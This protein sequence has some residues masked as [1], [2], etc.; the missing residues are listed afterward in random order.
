MFREYRF[1]VV[2]RRCS[3]C[4]QHFARVHCT[5]SRFNDDRD[6]EGAHRIP[7]SP[8]EVEALRVACTAGE[9]EAEAFLTSLSPREYTV[10]TGG[11]ARLVEGTVRLLPHD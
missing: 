1:S 2:L 7:L 3:S 6:D 11:P 9:A 10:E 8:A 5:L 4:D